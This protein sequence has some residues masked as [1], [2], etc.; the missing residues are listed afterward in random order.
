VLLH[1]GV[2]HTLKLSVGVVFIGPNPISSR[3]TE[4]NIF[5]STG[6]PDC[7]VRTGQGTV[8]SPVHA[9]SV[10]RCHLR[11]L[12]TLD[13]PVAH[14]IVRCDLMTVGLADVAD[15]NCA[16]DRWSGVRLAHRIVQ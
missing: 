15:A 5:L 3:W 12:G 13:S 16:A 2:F 4:S 11:P 6:A 8:H 9:T 1:L 14:R 7:P 10:D